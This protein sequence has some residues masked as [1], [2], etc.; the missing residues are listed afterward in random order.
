M[1]GRCGARETEVVAT[2]MKYW[3]C[4]ASMGAPIRLSDLPDHKSDFYLIEGAA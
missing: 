1:Q 4:R 3:M 2:A